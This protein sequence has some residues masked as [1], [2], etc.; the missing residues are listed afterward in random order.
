MII[1]IADKPIF[2]QSFMKKLF[3]FILLFIGLIGC[4]SK[5]A[6]IQ[7]SKDHQYK[8]KMA[9]QYYASHK[10]NFAQMLFEE[11]FPYIKGTASFEDVYYK[12][13]YCSYYE[14]DY[15]NS[16]NLFKTFVE[17]FP[18]SKN[19]EE[20]EYMRAFSYYKQSP[21]VELDQTTTNKTINLM[22]A[23]INTHP[24]S[25]RVKDAMLIMEMCREKLEAKDF[26]SAQL[27][28]DLGFYKAA[29]ISFSSLSENFPDSKKSDEYKL[30]VIKSY[31]KYAE[32]SIP[33]KQ[34]ERYEKTI[35]ECNDFMERFKESTLISEAEN[36]KNLS[37]NFIKNLKHE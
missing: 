29:A 30:L 4:T 17:T 21:K 1:N 5:F 34:L 26:K 24:T 18:N 37:N 7:K 3:Y 28:Y 20:C 16:E 13:A 6:K 27:Y 8:L 36:Y 10:Y 32:M 23:F 12:F 15:L 9:E 25:A 33:E 35:L 14:K 19:A 11:V 31:Y 2:L 22:Q